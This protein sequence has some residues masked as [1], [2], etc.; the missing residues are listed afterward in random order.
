MA[1]QTRTVSSH[2]YGTAGRT[3]A[4]RSAASPRRASSSS[5]RASGSGQFNRAGMDNRG[6][7]NGRNRKSHRRGRHRILKWTLG[8]IGT[9]LAIGIA[10][11]AYL[12]ITT[13]I[14]PAEKVALSSKTTVYYADGTTEIGSFANQNREI[15]SCGALPKYIGQAV[16]SSEN[17]SFYTDKGI[18]LKGIG[19][20]LFNNITTGSRQGG[21]TITQQYAERYYLGETTSYPGKLR[22]AVL[23]VK[24]AQSQDK[25]QVL[26]NYMNTI[27]FGRGAYGIQAAAKTYFNKGA[28]DLSVPEAAMLAGI[29]PSP[30]NW[31]PAENPTRAKSR[32]ERVITIMREDGYISSQQA[33]AAK[34]PD[35]IKGAQQDTYAGQQGYLLRMVRD[36][37]TGDKTFTKDE[38]DT[39]GYKIVTTI[40]KAKQDMIFKTASPSQ[41]GKGLVPAGLQTGAMSV[42]PK[43]GSIVAI[44]AGDDYLKK[45]LNNATQALYE[46]GSTM[47][48]FGLIGA[49]Q[50]GVSLNTTFNGNSPRTYDGLTSP[51]RNFGNVSYG[52]INLYTATA[53]SVNTVYMDIQ[54]HLGAKKIAQIANEAGV[55]SA[56]VTGD[57]PFTILGNDGVHVED[58][59]QAYATIANQGRKPKLHIVASVRDAGGNAMFKAPTTST[60]V[61]DA[62]TTA[63][64]A[65]AM[66]GTVQNGS[67]RE[68]RR[69]GKTIAAKTGT[70]NDAT[71]GSV[72]GFTPNTVSVFA[73]WYPDASGN[74]QRI[75][76]F[77]GYSGGSDYAVH[78]FTQYMTEALADT[79][80]EA[81]PTVTDNGRI[82]GSDGDWGTGAKT[83]QRQQAEAEAKRR[84]AEEAQ[85]Q[86]EE[87][88]AKKAQEEAD[89]NNTTQP[90]QSDE[91]PQPSQDSSSSSS[92]QSS[93]SQEQSGTVGSGSGAGAQKP[94]VQGSNSG[95]GR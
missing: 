35:T 85:K 42:N 45:Q 40:D 13:D 79:P 19:R 61:F 14:P 7:R 57:N 30:S 11:F 23:A 49:I 78:M 54:Q 74:P 65:K 34:F 12:Y 44:Y 59:A 84:A 28:R 64:V 80:D 37:L 21:S 48:P 90:D 71:A 53:N 3:A 51:V 62:N 18:D 92:S 69:I 50:S 46:P 93:Q 68:A 94:P 52:Y 29:I 20:A 8:I 58:I 67:A 43:D 60:Q 27:Y 70:A 89:Q 10:A 72:V 16:V 86:A 17:R 6:N 2:A 5:H 32:F 77:A 91:S 88:A 73:M 24:I 31:D 25:D 81:F 1:F 63:L 75:P 39:G 76:A 82:G 87:D 9:L 83:W 95:S 56:R 15:I 36:E 38:L 55:S 33:A 47:K 66:T 26:C 22:E 4:V 41:D